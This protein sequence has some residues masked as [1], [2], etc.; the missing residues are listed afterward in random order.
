MKHTGMIFHITFLKLFSAFLFI[1]LL[2]MALYLYFYGNSVRIIKENIIKN[3]LEDIWRASSELDKGIND[4]RK[5]VYSTG[6]DI[7]KLTDIDQQGQTDFLDFKILKKFAQQNVLTNS[8]LEDIIFYIPEKNYIVNSGGSY[9]FDKFFELNMDNVNKNKYYWKNQLENYPREQIHPAEA[10]VTIDSQNKK[11]ARNM[12]VLV[13]KKEIFRHFRMVILI[14]TDRIKEICGNNFLILNKSNNIIYGDMSTMPNMPGFLESINTDTGADYTSITAED[15]GNYYIFYYISEVYPWIYVKVFPYIEVLNKLNNLNSM[16]VIILVALLCASTIISYFF[17]SRFFRP[18]KKVIDLV[19]PPHDERKEK[20][21]MS[22][23]L[24][25]TWLHIQDICVKYA[26]FQEKYDR[27]QDDYKEYF[28]DKLIMNAGINDVDTFK[29]LKINPLEFDNFLVIY[30]KIKFKESFISRSETDGIQENNISLV[31]KELIVLTLHGL[32]SGNYSF[33]T[34]SSSYAFIVTL[35]GGSFAINTFMEKLS[36]YIE[37]DSE[38]FY[39]IM[40]VSN[41]YHMISDLKN[42]YTDALNVFA[43]HSLKSESQFLSNQ[44]IKPY[45]EYEYLKPRNLSEKL[46]SL[47]ELLKYDEAKQLFIDTLHQF[48]Q[49]KIPVFIIRNTFM[50]LMN[51]FWDSIRRN[52]GKS[53]ENKNEIISIYKNI[54]CCSVKSDFEDVIL[55]VFQLIHEDL[56]GEKREKSTHIVVEKIMQQVQAGYY[57]EL[58]LKLLA[59]KYNMTPEYLSKIFKDFTGINFSDYLKTARLEKAKGL[60]LKSNVRIKEIASE[61]GYNDSSNFIKVF[62]KEFGVSPN[63]YRTLNKL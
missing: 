54:E 62:K 60:L 50:G 40:A 31:V 16:A 48:E 42:A 51:D 27:L 14:H 28:Y 46:N 39:I 35:N 10:Y 1:I 2:S 26:N 38:Y 43:Y 5:F 47:V 34:E 41:T 63:E 37:V 4:L 6:I 55:S 23:E 61:V 49:Q 56:N 30:Y 36:D 8:L 3:E 29:N 24:D 33:Q 45:Y 32:C 44:S 52:C 13:T 21:K 19:L 15:G 7:S 25:R 18:I 22:N 9:S 57:E 58:S 12:I 20:G 53:I 17:S 59:Y 11:I